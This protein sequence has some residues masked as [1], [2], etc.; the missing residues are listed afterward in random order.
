M[1]RSNSR[2]LPGLVATG[3]QTPN[4]V[5]SRHLILEGELLLICHEG[6]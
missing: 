3:S 6:L 2:V 5:E 1:G 4:R